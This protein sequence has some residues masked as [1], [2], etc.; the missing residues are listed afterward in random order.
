MLEIR[1]I[2]FPTDTSDRVRRG[3]AFVRGLADRFD[4]EIHILH[5]IDVTKAPHYDELRAAADPGVE[6]ARAETEIAQR[7]D[8]LAAELASSPRPRKVVTATL[9]RLAPAEAICAYAEENDI[10]LVVTITHAKETLADR[11]FGRISADV[12]DDCG[13]SVLT[14][15]GRRLEEPL[16]LRRILVP[17]DYGES[18]SSALLAAADL[19]EQGGEVQLVHLIEE[20]TYPAFYGRPGHERTHCSFGELAAHT[21]SQLVEFWNE[22]T[23]NRR[24]D[25]VPRAAALE[26]HGAKAILTHAEET[27]TDLIVVGASPGHHVFRTLAQNLA[28]H[29]E[30]CPV[31]TLHSADRIAGA[32]QEPAIATRS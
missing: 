11:L 27:G 19:L 20:N 9:H 7:I 30:P 8:D 22:V 25:L 10:D 15:T 32:D 26:E 23:A 31:L 16:R 24:P 6:L 13:C 17:V 1:R 14:V 21:R 2:L 29:P 5:N 12:I 18:S 28:L 3:A 4:A